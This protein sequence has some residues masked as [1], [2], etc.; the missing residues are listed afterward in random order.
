MRIRLLFISLLVGSI[1]FG[2]GAKKNTPLKSK[3]PKKDTF[4]E[5]QWWLGFKAGINLTEADPLQRYTVL[6][7]T[8]YAAG[9]ADKT[10][11][12]F[13]KI[14]SQATVEISFQYKKFL[15]STQPT[16]RQSIY[17]YSNQ[18]QW[19]NSSDL[20]SSLQQKYDFEQHVSYAD[21]PFV[22]KYDI[23]GNKLRPYVQLGIY[24]SLLIDATQTVHVSGT[25]KASGGTNTYSNEAVIVGTKDLFTNYWGLMGGVGVSYQ[26]G[27]VK[28]I[29]D[30]LYLKGMSNVANTSNRYSNDRLSG[31]GDV[32][33][34]LKLNNIMV[35][36]GVLFPMRF[37]N[38]NFKSFDR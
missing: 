33:D 21:F 38:S 34:D 3:P 7:P 2:Q 11:D 15:F 13:K 1:A 4:L 25:D 9:L 30:A 14:G 29:L 5:K 36:A 16:Y 12:G 17:T 20:G 35:S 19:T 37:L 27:N 23:L 8:N 28:L 22:V 18:F 31:I 6:T 10:Y 24:Y 32:Q 26:L